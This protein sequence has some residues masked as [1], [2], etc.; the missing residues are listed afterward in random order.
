M[1]IP[2]PISQPKRGLSALTL[3]ELMISLSI[4][5]FMLVGLISVNLFGM[6]EDELVN[7]KLGANDQSRRGFD[8]LLSEIREAKNTMIGS[9]SDTTFTQVADGQLQQGNA[10]QITPSTNNSIYVRYYFY[11][12]PDTT[13]NEL[14]RIYSSDSNHTVV[15]QYL[16]TNTMIFT[17]MDYT[18]KVLTMHPSELNYNYCV[19]SVI[20]FYQY[21]Y[22][23]TQVGS[24]YYY[25]YYKMQ[26][27]ATRRSV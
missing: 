2:P 9:G 27:K 13:T 10:L 8:L 4:F 19:S 7:S 21:Q 6:K 1:K 20:Q 11:V 22:P 23:L 16:L 26:F 5:G 18:N 12:S 14:R 24:N 25:N 17:A 15:A 3:P